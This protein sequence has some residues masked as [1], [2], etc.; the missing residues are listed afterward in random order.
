M[1]VAT[2]QGGHGLSI[3][4]RL[5]KIVAWVLFVSLPAEVAALL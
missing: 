2:L 4:S 3:L 1:Q 5:A